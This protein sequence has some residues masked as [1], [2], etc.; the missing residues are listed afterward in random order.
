MPDN[1]ELP[2]GTD[3]IIGGASVTTTGDEPGGGAAA[4]VAGGPNADDGDT[5]V[6]TETTVATIVP[7]E[8]PGSASG[9]TG[10][11]SARSGSS[12]GGDGSMIEK[13]RSGGAQISGQATGKARDLFGQGLE[14]SAEALGNVSRMIGDT[15]TGLDE[16]L[17]PEYGDYARRAASAI[18]NAANN[19]AAK[20]ADA[21]IE[22]TRNF[23]RK[24]PTVALAGAAVV[25]FALARLVK[26]GLTG[27]DDDDGDD[28][29]E[30]TGRSGGSS[31]A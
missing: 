28:G 19:I 5:L 1:N 6:V 27:S 22:D 26:T 8:T 9:G 31:E 29:R 11:S 12:A 2:E 23:V 15:A 25:G 3:K 10:A 13:L 21:L 7:A 20:D 18:E 4:T 14:R 24:S 17:G 16:R 30:S